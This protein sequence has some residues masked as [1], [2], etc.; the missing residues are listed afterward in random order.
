MIHLYHSSMGPKEIKVNM[1]TEFQH[2]SAYQG[3]H[4]KSRSMGSVEEISSR[5]MDKEIILAIK[6]KI[7]SF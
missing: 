1:E 3:T 5:C 7:V 2:S 6:S 4:H